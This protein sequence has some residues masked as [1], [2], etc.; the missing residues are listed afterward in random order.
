MTQKEKVARVSR[1]NELEFW[2]ESEPLLLIVGDWTLEVKINDLG[3]EI[4]MH[5][6]NVSRT[7]HFMRLNPKQ[8]ALL[9]GY[10]DHYLPQS[11]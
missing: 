7:T 5:T 8:A 2:M 6:G 3:T 1:L 10:L 4:M 11:F 9:H